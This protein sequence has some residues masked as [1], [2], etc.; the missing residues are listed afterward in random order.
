MVLFFRNSIS[1]ANASHGRSAARASA[2]GQENGSEM[3]PQQL[4]SLKTDSEIA[5]RRL[6]I[7]KGSAAS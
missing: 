5:S 6:A 2:P 4:K 1:S 7:V 3:A